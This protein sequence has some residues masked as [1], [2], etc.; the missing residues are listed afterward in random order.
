M[1]TLY[2]DNNATTQI[3][4]RVLENMQRYQKDIYGNSSSHHNEG[5]RSSELLSL[6]RKKIASLIN[7]QEDEIIFTA[8]GTE[9]DNMAVRGYMIKFKPS[10]AHLIVSAVEHPAVLNTAKAL[11]KDG[12]RV[13]FAPVDS[14]GI[15]D[16][17]KLKS[18]IR[19]DTK[20]ISVMAANNE[21][22]ALQPIEA[23]GRI[24]GENGIAFHTDAVQ[25]MGKLPV[26][27]ECIGCSMLSASAH[28]FYGP[29]GVGFLYLK[30]GIRIRP[31]L[32]GG[33]HENQ[34]RP[35]T[36]NVPLIAAMADALE[37]DIEE[38]GKNRER[39]SALRDR[40]KKGISNM[41]NILINT[42]EESVYNTLNVSF[43]GI[44]GESMLLELDSKGI[45]VSTG[46]ACSSD[47]LDASH[48]MMAMGRDHLQSHGSL[49]ISLGKYNTDEE[50]D[51]AIRVID[52]SIKRIRNISPYK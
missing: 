40:L 1:K 23:I 4:S 37:Y 8:T 22:G 30:K 48:V 33:R 28:K 19:E 12:F 32:T 46:S 43:P 31:V 41:D 51:Y 35:G 26:D 49:R 2:L 21:T 44:E 27:V 17:K 29:K 34:Q 16:M 50:I 38:M 6:S 7:A 5:R 20:L 13:D 42:P 45:C 3:D 14:N 25:I 52:E 10:E 36:V 47:S 24:A 18:L 15:V 39:I 11:Q 9:S